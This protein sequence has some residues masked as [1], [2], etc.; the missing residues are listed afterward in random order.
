MRIRTRSEYA[1]TGPL[2]GQRQ[3]SFIG[4]SILLLVALGFWLSGQAQNVPVAVGQSYQT[5]TP[6]ATGAVRTRASARTRTPGPTRTPT[7]NNPTGSPTPIPTFVNTPTYTATFTDAPTDT[8]TFVPTPTDAPT[9]TATLVPT[10]TDTPIYEPTTTE[11]LVVTPIPTDTPTEEPTAT[12]TLD[13]TP[14]PTETLTETPVITDTITPTLTPTSTPTLTPTPA[15]TVTLELSTHPSESSIAPGGIVSYTVNITNSSEITATV[16]LTA[17]DSNKTSFSS[18]LESD[19]FVLGPGRAS[20]TI[21]T[22][23]ASS[24]AQDYTNDETTIGASVEGVSYAESIVTTRLLYVGFNRALAGPGT[25]DHFAVPDS[26]IRMQVGISSTVQ[27]TQTILTEFVPNGWQVTDAGGGSLAVLDDESQRIEWTLKSVAGGTP[28]TRTYTLQSPPAAI[29]PPEYSF[30]AMASSGGQRFFSSPWSVTLRHPLVLSHYRIG[31][32]APLDRMKYAANADAP[33]TALP[34]FKAFRVR[35]Q[36]VNDQ[37]SPVL[38]LPRLEWSS[39]SSGPFQTIPVGEPKLGEP[40]Y[41]RPVD[42]AAD[43]ARIRTSNFGTGWDTHAPQE[44]YI[45]TDR[46]PGPALTL[47]A[48]SFTEIEF[49]VRATAD[50]EYRQAY[51]FRLSDDERLLTGPLAQVEMESQPALEL[52][53]PQYHGISPNAPS[54]LKNRLTLNSSQ[55]ETLANPHGPYTLTGSDCGSCHRNH[56]GDNRNLLPIPAAQSNLCFTCHDGSA[57]TANISSQFSDPQVPPNNP[58][59]GAI[60]S[61]PATTPSAHLA[62]KDDEFH[63]TLNRHSECGDCHNSHSQNGSL[64]VETANGYAASGALTNIS[65]VGVTGASR[66][67][68]WEDAIT[69]EYEL[70]YKCHSSYTVLPSSPRET[71]QSAEFNPANGSFHPIEQAGKNGT[72]AMANNLGGT[73][74]Y[75]LWNF[76]TGDTVRCLNCHGD[77]RLANPAAPPPANAR[78]APHA[79]AFVGMLM[80]NLR[81]RLLKSS[82]EGYAASDFALCYQCHAEAPF[83]DITADPRDDTNFRFHGFHLNSIPNIGSGG[84][85]IDTPGAGQGNALCSECHYQPH[86]QGSAR[87]NASGSGLVNLAPDVQ[88][89]SAQILEWDPNGRT[90]SLSCHGYDHINAGY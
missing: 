10:P 73:S 20:V 71:D 81:D 84:T 1:S 14:T 88:P 29:P 27:L 39:Q 43:G 30:Q 66:T 68:V 61:H 23:S 75:K 90:C 6:T 77:Y 54:A 51:F 58:G 41:V 38:W 18:S 85:S 50:A 9:D 17:T 25:S 63:D 46:N 55:D 12:A 42:D 48:Y 15:I 62:A 33:S 16:E 78:L 19:R 7:Q 13:I 36:V 87:G 2:L 31:W 4:V 74:P 37:L 35:F 57:A 28:M 34:R 3:W 89:N 67:L 49:S 76:G 79:N 22:V 80:N 52:T 86:G 21:L 32:D 56:T 26:P 82:G 47:N 5:N 44:G 65:G 53:Q 69:Y 72:T 70:C 8:A 64:A 60:Y 24:E 11:T 83:K 40:F 59:G 45:F